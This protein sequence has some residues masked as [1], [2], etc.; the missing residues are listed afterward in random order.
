LRDWNINTADYDD[1]MNEAIAVERWWIRIAGCIWLLFQLRFFWFSFNGICQMETVSLKRATTVMINN[2]SHHVRGIMKKRN[3]GW[4]EA[5]DIMFLSADL[6]HSGLMDEQEWM[7][8]VLK[9]KF[10]P[11]KTQAQRIFG[12]LANATE[13]VGAIDIATLSQLLYKPPP[14]KR[15]HKKG[16]TRMSAAKFMSATIKGITSSSTGP[17]K[18]HPGVPENK[19]SLPR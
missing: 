3:C 10:G 7:N 9:H 1:W 15:S 19:R 18:A 8:F 11:N 6:D 4:D 17:P 5:L 13:G 12:R 16:E 2:M 14:K